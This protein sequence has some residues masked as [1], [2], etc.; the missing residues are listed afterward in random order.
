[1]N[2]IICA[3]YMPSGSHWEAEYSFIVHKS[4]SVSKSLDN[5]G[6]YYAG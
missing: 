3:G 6:D 5:N 1:M 4:R 2:L